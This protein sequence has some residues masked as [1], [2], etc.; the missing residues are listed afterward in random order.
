MKKFKWLAVLALIAVLAVPALTFAQQYVQGGNTAN[1]SCDDLKDP[2][3]GATTLMFILCRISLLINSIIPVLIALGVL[4]FIYGVITYVIAKDEEA[5]GRG[6][7]VMINGLIGLLV[8]T[9]IWGLIFIL[10]RTFRLNDTSA[11]QVPCIESPGID[12]P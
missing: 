12:C 9:T 10:K 6:R 8:I 5:K 4:Y 2:D 11:I 1:I 3:T 7:D